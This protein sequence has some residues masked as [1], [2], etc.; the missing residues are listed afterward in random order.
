[1]SSTV[2]QRGVEGSDRQGDLFQEVGDAALVHERIW[3]TGYYRSRSDLS[4]SHGVAQVRQKGG[5]CPGRT[6]PGAR[7]T[8]TG[9]NGKGFSSSGNRAP[10]SVRRPRAAA[11]DPQTC[12]SGRRA[13]LAGMLL[14]APGQGKEDGMWRQLL[15]HATSYDD[16]ISPNEDTRLEALISDPDSFRQEREILRAEVDRILNRALR[17]LPARER[18]ILERRFGMRDGSELTLEAVSRIL[19]LSKERV[20]QLEREA[21]L[22]LRLTL[23]GM[24]SQLMGA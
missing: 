12:P 3:R 4:K 10:F 17:Q 13:P 24:R 22:K 11:F 14:C 16:F 1:M 18:Y 15:P 8:R 2:G 19:K 23:D 20:R 7:T 6:A 5:R 9:P 21:L